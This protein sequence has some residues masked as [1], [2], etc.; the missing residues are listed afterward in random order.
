MTPD[1]D[2]IIE[3]LPD[4]RYVIT[5]DDWEKSQK[6]W[7]EAIRQVYVECISICADIRINGKGGAP[8]CEQA[9]SKRAKEYDNES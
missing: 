8:T 7:R 5:K 2:I 6:A 9:L 3:I 4:G 1:N